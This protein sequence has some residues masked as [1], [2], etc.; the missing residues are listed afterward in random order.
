MINRA[1]K[2]WK[3]K[4]LGEVCHFVRGPFGG[5]LKKDIFKPTGYAVY[6]QQHAIYD[7]FDDVRYY[8]DEDKFNDMKRFELNSGDLIMSC[9]GT[10]GKIAIVPENIKKGIINQALL[11]LSPSNEISSVFLKLWM[12]SQSFQESLK[13]YS[14]GAAIQNVA[15]VAILKNI[16]IPLPP[17]PQQKKIV[18]VLDTAS[19]LVEKQKVLLKNYDLFLK[20]KFIEMFGDPVKN[21][22][23]WNS[24]KIRSNI[25]KTANEN[26]LNFPTKEYLYIDIGS[27]ENK[28][29]K[30]QNYILGE[31]SP[32]R[33]RQLTLCHDILVATIRPNL[34]NVAMVKTKYPDTLS[35][36]GFCL[37]RAD[38]MKLNP[39]YLFEVVKHKTFISFLINVAKGASYPAVSNNDI[40]NLQIAIPPIELQD[41]FAQIVEQT[42]I[43]KQK[44]QQKLEKLQTLYDAL[45][46][47]AFDGE[48][49]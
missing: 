26:P 34:N 28:A 4:N 25:Q 14:Q 15:S 49:E 24:G 9:S 5:S 37:L 29:I 33:A 1:S 17:L 35:S 32:S 21:P 40:L 38:D 30:E 43:L 10:M 22:M 23:G 19:T 44:E 47:R 7:Q 6:E 18:R 39:Y 42:E 8:I 11:K 12:E 36:T 13:K 46:Q 31:N 16:E 48:I 2:S 45:M 27:L 3:I 20:S 41:E